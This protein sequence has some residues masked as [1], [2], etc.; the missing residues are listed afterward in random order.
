MRKL[1]DA[2]TLST[3]HGAKGLQF[4]IVFVYGFNSGTIPNEMYVKEHKDAVDDLEAEIAEASDKASDD[5]RPI[6][7]E[8]V[9]ALSTADSFP[10]IASSFDEFVLEN[11]YLLLEAD[12]K[13]EKEYLELYESR[14]HSFLGRESALRVNAINSE[15][16]ELGRKLSALDGLTISD[17]AEPGD[18]GERIRKRIALLENEKKNISE[19]RVAL[20]K[21]SE[22]MRRLAKICEA[23]TATTDV[24]GARRKIIDERMREARMEELRVF[25]V[26][27]SRAI[28]LLYLCPVSGS[29]RSPYSYWL[30]KN[31]YEMYMMVDGID[32]GLASINRPLAAVA[33]AVSRGEGAIDEIDT[34]LD[35]AKG[36]YKNDPRFK[37]GFPLPQWWREGKRTVAV[38]YDRAADV[39]CLGNWVGVPI[40]GALNASL[41][42]LVKVVLAGRFSK[43]TRIPVP[44]GIEADGFSADV[45][46]ILSGTADGLAESM[47]RRCLSTDAPVWNS[48]G[49]LALQL[50]MLN[51]GRPDEKDTTDILKSATVLE[52][53]RYPESAPQFQKM[54]S[55]AETLMGRVGNLGKPRPR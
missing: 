7:N 39:V 15:I 53:S 9:E 42:E 51:R 26:A 46:R 24:F 1:D 23:Q 25:Y 36:R 5:I 34:L 13:A 54:L 6:L 29:T 55:S 43:D 21:W 18:R 37:P 48:A 19:R 32:E 12:P 31:E 20:R 28:D 2:V 33:E 38:A 8:I 44:T 16:A 27:V 22:P 14:I 50:F 52:S 35:R 3:I 11:R 4:P 30:P 49:C 10:D 41:Y 17:R 40:D 45:L 47:L